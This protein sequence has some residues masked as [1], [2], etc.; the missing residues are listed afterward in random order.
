MNLLTLV[1]RT[2][3]DTYVNR[4]QVFRSGSARC[5]RDHGHDGTHLHINDKSYTVE[6]S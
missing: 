6:W 3:A 4:C 5:Y 2:P 1:R